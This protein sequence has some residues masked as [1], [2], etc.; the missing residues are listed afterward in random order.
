MIGRNAGPK[1][2]PGACLTGPLSSAGRGAEHRMDIFAASRHAGKNRGA[3]VG[4]EAPTEA[5][6]DRQ[7][8]RA[9][10]SHG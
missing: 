7:R 6:R 8:I 9:S 10:G 4:P 5:L 3:S 1:R 2:A